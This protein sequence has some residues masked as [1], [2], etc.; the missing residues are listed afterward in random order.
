VKKPLIQYL[1]FIVVLL[2][3]SCISAF[4]QNNK[5]VI[6][7]E[8]SEGIKDI[9][10]KVIET[11]TS[12]EAKLEAIHDWIV[13]RT[14]YDVEKYLSHDLS[15]QKNIETIKGRLAVCTGYA[16][17]MNEMCYWAGIKCIT[18]NGYAKNENTDLGDKFYLDT[19][20]WNAV[21]LNNQWYFVDATWDAGYIQYTK[22]KFLSKK[23]K[24]QPKFVSSPNKKY[25]KK[26]ASDFSK[27]HLPLNPE[28]QLNAKKITL[29]KFEKDSSFYLNANQ[30]TNDAEALSSEYETYLLNYAN[31]NKWE[32]IADDGKEGFVFNKRNFICRG[33]M[34]KAKMNLLAADLKP[35]KELTV[36]DT[37]Q[38]NL[39]SKYGLNAIDSFN[40]MKPML[41]EMKTELMKNNQLKTKII[42]SDN[43]ALLSTN[44]KIFSSFNSTKKKMK[45][46]RKTNKTLMKT[47][48]KNV[49]HFLSELKFYQTKYSKTAKAEDTLGL[50]EKIGLLKDSVKYLTE[51]YL[52]LVK[53]FNNEYDNDITKLDQYNDLTLKGI[54][55]LKQAYEL[56]LSMIDDLDYP[57]QTL[58]AK[59]TKRQNNA[60]GLLLNE[61][62]FLTDTLFK[63]FKQIQATHV[64]VV[65]NQ[66]K[67]LKLVK[68]M[69]RYKEESTA[70]IQI[71]LDAMSGME[72][73]VYRHKDFIRK[74]SSKCKQLNK[75]FSKK[76][77][78]NKLEAKHLSK[79]IELEK[80]LAKARGKMISKEIT[81]YQKFCKTSSSACVKQI[82]S[83][84]RLKQNLSK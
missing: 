33:L 78:A 56:R 41:T 72:T 22:H 30:F 48:D 39:I 75:Q 64:K 67:I 55:D 81:T 53:A 8:Y 62:V 28:W 80:M 20:C 42:T 40:K 11:K 49:D 17:L 66:K 44:K 71:Y 16:E 43:G 46:Q 18:I 4:A 63:M 69:R 24:F 51:D 1:F 36:A 38:L 37:N 57:I 29:K 73:F 79:E 54:N 2:Q 32:Q 58:K 68:K 12:D 14:E 5:T 26:S 6:A 27:D 19:H 25:F 50:E 84:N 34:N 3:I 7:N 70:Q 60:D 35:A 10:F 45:L 13:Y 9:T 74:F 59:F 82:K 47:N 31:E 23:I 15:V 52:I 76:S 83:N 21:L 61:N 77:A 65:N